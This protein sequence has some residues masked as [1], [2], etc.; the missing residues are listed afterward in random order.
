MKDRVL[1]S[2]DKK[3]IYCSNNHLARILSSVS[4]HLNSCCDADAARSIDGSG[5]SKPSLPVS[6]YVVIVPLPCKVSAVQPPVYLDGPLA[7]A[8]QMEATDVLQQTCRAVAHV[9]AQ[10][11]QCQHRGQGC[12]N[13]RHQRQGLLAR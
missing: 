6:Q 11:C 7:P 9:D 12:W 13:K 1:D 2:I 3:T 5:R 4:Y 10:R 8:L